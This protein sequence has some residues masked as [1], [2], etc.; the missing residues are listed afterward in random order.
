VFE[1]LFQG[2]RNR[3]IEDGF[4]GD[5]PVA[6]YRVV[7]G[8]GTRITWVKAHIRDADGVQISLVPGGHGPQDIVRIVQINIFVDHNDVL[9]LREGR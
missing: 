8:T 7:D 9:Q 1:V 4:T 3:A 2:E 5:A 6:P